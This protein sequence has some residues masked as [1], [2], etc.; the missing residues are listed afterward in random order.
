MTP[1]GKK[2]KYPGNEVAAWGGRE[3]GTDKRRGCY[4]REG[5]KGE[6]KRPMKG[7]VVQ[8]NFQ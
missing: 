2:M 8:T 3:R 5:G 6:I 4:G 1:A 7:C